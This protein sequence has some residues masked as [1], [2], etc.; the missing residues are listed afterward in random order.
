MVTP[1]KIAERCGWNLDNI[2]FLLS[3]L[4]KCRA[5]GNVS[6][7]EV[8][9]SCYPELFRCENDRCM[10]E[11][12]DEKLST[13]LREYSTVTGNVIE[14]VIRGLGPGEISRLLQFLIDSNLTDFA[15]RIDS[16][17]PENM[18]NVPLTLMAQINE[19]VG[20][21]LYAAGKFD[22]ASRRFKTAA[23]QYRRAGVEDRSLFVEAFS[24]VAEAEKLKNE[25]ERLHEE[26]RHDLEEKYLRDASR[27][28]AESSTL[29]KRC[30]STILEAYVNSV[31]S[32][33]DALEVLGNYY[34]THGMV[35]EAEKYFTMCS[36]EVRR[37]KV[38]ISEEHRSLLELKEKSCTAM[39]RICRAILENSPALYEEAG[40]IFR[41]LARSGYA[42]DVMVELASIAYKSAVELYDNIDDVL[43][44][45]PKYVDLAVEYIDSRVRLRYGSFKHML[46]ELSTRPLSAVSNELKVDEYALKMYIAYK[47]MEEEA[48]NEARPLILD[49]LTLVAGLGLD[50]VMSTGT[51]LRLEVERSGMSFENREYLNTL[52]R[53]LDL[54]QKR[55][56]EIGMMI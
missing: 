17:V 26:E 2:A 29:F 48:G 3:L 53:L 45:Y 19:Q 14:N 37:S 16:S 1:E 39:S 32:M 41:D 13:I 34:F 50:P 11:L 49:V 5:L 22:E 46:R 9:K 21:L 44:V 4:L 43:R 28:Y 6:S 42:P 51:D 24:K 8:S 47:I 38:G 35:D 33:A 10:L 20:T 12:P 7:V 25:A 15:D 52:C 31:L 55:L 36:D 18:G 56:R 27:L 40:D 30:S 54:V 23:E